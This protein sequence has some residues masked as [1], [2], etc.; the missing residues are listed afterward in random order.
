M[1]LSIKIYYFFFIYLLILLTGKILIVL[2]FNSLHLFHCV[3]NELTK[4]WLI[5]IL[6]TIFI[7]YSCCQ[8][9]QM[10][11][12]AIIVLWHLQCQMFETMDRNDFICWL[13]RNEAYNNFR[14]ELNFME[15]TDWLENIFEFISIIILICS[16]PSKNLWYSQYWQYYRP[17]PFVNKIST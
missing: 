6:I 7:F 9:N 16:W 14:R 11:F 12:V 5:L 8:T 4:S 15:C 13:K 3:W 10:S 1:I 17:S 2:K